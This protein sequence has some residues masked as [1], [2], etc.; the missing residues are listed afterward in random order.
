MYSICHEQQYEGW[1]CGIW[2]GRPVKVPNVKYIVI[3]L[4]SKK[5]V[6]P[7]STLPCN[8]FG[9][10]VITHHDVENVRNARPAV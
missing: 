5:G 6:T 3:D 7:I 8:K 10:M 4:S 1:G 2:F 9:Y